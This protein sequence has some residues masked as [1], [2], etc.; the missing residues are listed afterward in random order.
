MKIITQ[1]CSIII[2][3][4]SLLIGFI[5]IK[6]YKPMRS[7]GFGAD[8]DSILKETPTIM[9]G[10]DYFNLKDNVPQMSLFASEMESIGEDYVLFTHPNGQ[11]FY[12]DKKDL[13][14]KVINYQATQAEYLKNKNMLKLMRQV[15]IKSQDSTYT[16]DLLTYYFLKEKIIAKGTV[17]LISFDPKKFQTIQIQSDRMIAYPMKKWS[18]FYP[19]ATGEVKDS[20]NKSPPMKFRAGEIVFDGLKET[21]LMDNK[22]YIER[23]K[24][25]LS[26]RKGDIFLENKNKKLKYLVFNDDVKLHETIIMSNGKEV[27]RKGFSERLEGFGREDMFVLSGAPRVEQGEDVVKGYKITL[28]EKMEFIEIDDAMSDLSTQKK[29][30]K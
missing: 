9:K 14:T 12:L 16:G 19:L 22:A 5:F 8:T 1:K 2:F 30:K 26:A 27:I 3:L 20:F 17:E 18:K 24:M 29:E 28:R 13:T 23:G 25:N 10:I 15:S 6:S 4:F 11:F 7:D 21:I